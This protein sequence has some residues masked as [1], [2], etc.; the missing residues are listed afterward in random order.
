MRRDRPPVWGLLV[1]LPLSLEF[2]FC[3]IINPML[4]VLLKVLK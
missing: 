1:I 2:V 3:N 4:I